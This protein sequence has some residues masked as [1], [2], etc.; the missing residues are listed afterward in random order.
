[1]LGH[2]AT[3]T[4]EGRQKDKRVPASQEGRQKDKRVP[5]L[6]NVSAR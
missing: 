1:M 6:L 4:Q 3:P 5:A 2:P